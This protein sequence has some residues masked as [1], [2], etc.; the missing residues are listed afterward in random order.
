M[1]R[2]VSVRVVGFTDVE[3]HSLRTLLR[4]SEGR[5]IAYL[6][7]E[8]G[9]TPDLTLIDSQSYEAVLELESPS[10]AGLRM[11]WIGDGQPPQAVL[12][13]ARPVDWAAV[14][15]AMDDLVQPAT[16]VD[17]DFSRPAPL[18]AAEARRVLI[19]SA[20]R[21]HRLYL[22]ARLALSGLTQ[23]DEA[24]TVPDALELARQQRYDVALVDLQ[25]PHDGGWSLA[26]QLKGAKPRIPHLIVTQGS[27]G[28]S[29][30]LKAWMAGVETAPG[31]PPNPAR[32]KALL[33]RV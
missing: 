15:A 33:D 11:I 6:P 32:L 28:T 13:F 8:G 31:S 5:E 16:L 18:D 26:R 30:R 21:D 10:N 23:A 4:L 14:V 20:D 2:T 12:C 29:E 17:L 19:A 7:W 27:S 3:R 1:A 22:R 25:L 24:E 9:G